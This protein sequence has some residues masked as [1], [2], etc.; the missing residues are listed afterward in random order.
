M[1]KEEKKLIRYTEMK[2]PIRYE[3]IKSI[4]KNKQEIE[5][6]VPVFFIEVRG[7]GEKNAILKRNLTTVE[8]TVSKSLVILNA[9][10]N[11][12]AI[13]EQKAAVEQAKLVIESISADA[14]H[15]GEK[16]AVAERKLRPSR[17]GKIIGAT[18]TVAGLILWKAMGGDFALFGLISSPWIAGIGAAIFSIAALNSNAINK[19]EIDVVAN[20]KL[21]KLLKEGL[22]K[23]DGLFRELSKIVSIYGTDIGS[24]VDAIEKLYKSAEKGWPIK[25]DFNGLKSAPKVA[26]EKTVEKTIGAKAAEL[27][28][29]VEE[30]KPKGNG[31][32]AEKT[33]FV[34]AKDA[35]VPDTNDKYN[36]EMVQQVFNKK[37][38]GAGKGNGAA[39]PPDVT[40][41]EEGMEDIYGVPR[42]SAEQGGAN[43]EFTS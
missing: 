26:E 27:P 39:F 36:T 1:L 14:K 32:G 11:N 31:N 12:T 37:G 13:P 43:S 17:I 35:E 22:G 38:N 25:G 10:G 20:G 4:D 8:D 30:S 33:E 3:L 42:P 7:K 21:E 41:H 24:K 28:Q 19:N 9:I 5:I 18:I 15:Y 16:L 6:K 2:A 34:V 29:N 23:S 40:L